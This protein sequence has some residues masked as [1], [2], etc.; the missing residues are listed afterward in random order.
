DLL[1]GPDKIVGI[2]DPGY[3]DARNIFL[4]R[5]QQVQPLPIDDQGLIIDED[6]LARC[7]YV[8]V[9]PSHQSPT[10]VRM[11]LERKQELLRLAQKHDFIVIEDDYESENCLTN[12]ASPSLKSLDQTGRVIYIS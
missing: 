3:P 6:A 11:S 12:E 2:E 8:Y 4:S 7:D 1:V 10:T 5:T 9:T